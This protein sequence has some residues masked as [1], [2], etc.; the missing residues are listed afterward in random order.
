MVD[1]Y[2]GDSAIAQGHNTSTKNVYQF[3][4]CKFYSYRMNGF[5]EENIIY[6]AVPY[7]LSVIFVC[8]FIY[9]YILT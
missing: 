3:I 9:F 1:I 6:Y 8:G 5:W 4:D 7:I 2:V